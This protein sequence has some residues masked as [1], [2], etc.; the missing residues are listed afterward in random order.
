M[1]FLLFCSLYLTSYEVF[2]QKETAHWFFGSRAG[3]Y[4]DDRGPRPDPGS[5]MLTHNGCAVIS[6]KHTGDLLFYSNGRNVWN[7]DHQLM[8][9]GQDFPPDCWSDITQA[10][11][12]VPFP[13]NE[14]KF[15]LFSIYY[16]EQ[17]G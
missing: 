10:A 1:R 16:T 13:G 8:P 2:S 15:Y 14:S 4:F 11:L 5:E 9:N 6:D 12:I 3:L 17:L 7:R